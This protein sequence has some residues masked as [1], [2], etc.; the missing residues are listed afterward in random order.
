MIFGLNA[1]LGKYKTKGKWNYSNA[2]A[3]IK[4]TV[5]KNY[6]INSW[7]FGKLNNTRESIILGDLM[8]II[9]AH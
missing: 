1:L 3:L 2:E 9:H 8:T 6:Q 7:E 4:Y 5:K